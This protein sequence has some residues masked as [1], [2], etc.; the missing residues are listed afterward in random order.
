MA[1]HVLTL[2]VFMIV[3]LL[4]VLQATA[5]QK[6]LSI[7]EID[8][9]QQPMKSE[10]AR[11]RVAIIGAGAAGASSAYYLNKH[12]A[13]GVVPMNIT[14]FERSSQVGGRVKS[15]D[16]SYSP[17]KDIEVGASSFSR[18]DRLL[19]SAMKELGVEEASEEMFAKGIGIWNGREFIFIQPWDSSRWWNRAK[20]IWKY[21]WA[22]VRTEDLS[23]KT[24]NE[25]R[26]QF[27]SG[28]PPLGL[29]SKVASDSILEE[30]ITSSA[31]V[32]LQSHNIAPP[33][34]TEIIQAGTR[35]H[36]SENLGTLHGL[37]S[38]MAMNRESTTSIKGGNWLLFDR[39]VNT[40]EA[41][42][43]LNTQVTKINKLDDGTFRLESSS[44]EKTADST[45]LDVAEYDA[46]IIAAPFQFTDIK[47]QLPL[48]TRPL[49][50]PYVERHV[51][52][53]TSS[54]T[55]SPKAFNLSLD[56]S[57]PGDV[58][59]TLD[60]GADKRRAEAGNPAFFSITTPQ[61]FLRKSVWEMKLEYVYKI[62]SSSPINDTTIAHLLGFPH[63]DGLPLPE[64]D[65]RWVHRQS[66][67][68]AY[69]LLLPKTKYGHIQLDRH[70]Y[71]SGEIESIE[72]SMEMS[73]LMGKNIAR[74]LYR[75][76]TDIS[77]PG[78]ERP[79]GE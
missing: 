37:A 49:E 52:Y 11:K 70:L 40:S 46:V 23:R 26:V 56:S 20:L 17:V 44:T 30:S 58:L 79:V 10:G 6:V 63:E 45:R 33:F 71:Y 72:S 22:P 76:W 12:A 77:E 73:S 74:L 27:D 50:I 18:E 5:D 48:A 64:Q 55:L 51:T 7:Q 25:L 43:Q 21:G 39:M 16:V 47:V 61:R 15:V 60:T 57:V 67:P 36:Y 29:L 65:V 62:L 42:L 35:A 2:R 4:Y 32:F 3:A 24:I 75:D 8:N 14:I 53:F 1:N 34:S 78:T 13:L 9:V 41:L 59:T 19:M 69:P 31:E 54:H 38:M 28:S 68:H 66:W